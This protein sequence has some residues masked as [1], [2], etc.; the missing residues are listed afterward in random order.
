MTQHV[1]LMDASFSTASLIVMPVFFREL[2]NHAY[3]NPA[4]NKIGSLRHVLS[5]SGIKF[6]KRT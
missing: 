6:T 4:Q 5:Q 2:K 3:F 1:S